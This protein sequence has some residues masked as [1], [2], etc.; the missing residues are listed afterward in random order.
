MS[1]SSSGL[2]F[3]GGRTSVGGGVDVTTPV[4]PATPLACTTRFLVENGKVSSYT[5]AGAGWGPV[6]WRLPPRDA[7]FDGDRAGP[8]RPA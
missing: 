4:R 1:F 6:G 3:G 8:A 7:C 5:F 2:G